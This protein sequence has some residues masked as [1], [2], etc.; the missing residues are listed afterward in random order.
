MIFWIMCM[1]KICTKTWKKLKFLSFTGFWANTNFEMMKLWGQLFCVRIL[2]VVW[3]IILSFIVFD[4]SVGK[5]LAFA[6]YLLK[7]QVKKQ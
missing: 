6:N 2:T 1:P 4:K 3:N 5:I 7:L